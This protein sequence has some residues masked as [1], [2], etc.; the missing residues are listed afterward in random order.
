MK[1]LPH[2]IGAATVS[3][4]SRGQGRR[5]SQACAAASRRSRCTQTKSAL[6]AAASAS[7]RSRSARPTPPRNAKANS[8][9]PSL[10]LRAALHTGGSGPGTATRASSGS[11]ILIEAVSSSCGPSRSLPGP[12]AIGYALV[13]IAG[14]DRSLHAPESHTLAHLVADAG[15]GK[16]D[17]STLQLLDEAQQLVAGA[18]VDEVH[19]FGVEEHML[20]RWPAC[21]Q[22]KFQSPDEVADAGKEQISTHAPNQHPREDERVGVPF[23]IAIGLRARQLA[24]HR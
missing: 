22:R 2:W 5:D 7:A 1:S 12:D 20:R 4:T 18:G 15:E 11:L 3:T 23:D 10:M 13:K 24:E 16:G 6:P 21:G 17:T 14:T 19:R 8:G 9:R